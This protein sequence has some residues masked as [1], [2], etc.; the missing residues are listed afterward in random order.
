MSSVR[1]NSFISF[2]SYEMKTRLLN[3]PVH[4]TSVCCT[5]THLE[6]IWL[7][8][9][10][11][12]LHDGTGRRPKEQIR[13]KSGSLFNVRLSSALYLLSLCRKSVKQRHNY[14]RG[15]RTPLVLYIIVYVKPRRHEIGVSLY[16]TLT[17]L[18]SVNHKSQHQV[19]LDSANQ[20]NVFLSVF[21][22]TH[23]SSN[24]FSRLIILCWKERL[25]WHE[26]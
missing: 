22:C 6:Y 17:K 5:G 1:S 21:K 16:L 19:Y 18:L 25:Y 20:S 23:T 7:Y 9:Q 13:E 24:M 12:L 4:W 2:K 26:I 11:V 14:V 3:H 15:L 10:T 8:S